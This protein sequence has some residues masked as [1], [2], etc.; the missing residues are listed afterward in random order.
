MNLVEPPT[1][2][3]VPQSGLMEY[4][5]RHGSEAP[6]VAAAPEKKA[7][8]K[9]PAPRVKKMTGPAPAPVVVAPVVVPDAPVPEKKVRAAK[10]KKDAALADV[11]APAPEKKPRVRKA[12]AIAAEETAAEPVAAAAPAKKA[13]AR[14]A[15]AKEDRDVLD[16]LED[17]LHSA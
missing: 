11:D 9:A 6:P 7:A 12:K 13:R 17:I 15:A 10:K 16:I 2:V 8:K 4:G 3:S 14:R 5:H 1:R